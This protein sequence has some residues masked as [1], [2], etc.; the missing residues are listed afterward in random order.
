MGH[1]RVRE[2]VEAERDIDAD[3]GPWHGGGARRPL[4]SGGVPAGPGVAELS[5]LQRTAGNGAVV[6]ALAGVRPAVPTPPTAAALRALGP[7]TFATGGERRSVAA[8]G[9]SGSP[10]TVVTADSVGGTA[11]AVHDG[12]HS[13]RAA[14]RLGVHAYT[15]RG[16]I[17]LGAGLHEAHGPGREATLAHELAHAGQMRM[18]GPVASTAVAEAE[19]A[20][21]GHGVSADRETP[22][23]LFWLIPVAVG[24]Y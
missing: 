10:R 21:G 18:R 12:P 14:A 17:A 4:E 1:L 2:R 5:R 19:V 3:A 16:E 23:G 11:V 20:S 6:R 9:I 15:F 22:H 24:A 8:D 13:H 7:A